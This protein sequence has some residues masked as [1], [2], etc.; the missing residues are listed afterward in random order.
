METLY[1]LGYF[2]E[3][4]FQPSFSNQL[5]PRLP[6]SFKELQTR[7]VFGSSSV[8][9]NLPHPMVHDLGDH[10]YVSIT[11]CLRHHLAHGITTLPLEH[12]EG[13]NVSNIS[14]S[15]RAQVVLNR[16]LSNNEKNEETILPVLLLK[17]SDDFEPNSSKQN[18]SSVWI[19]TVT[20]LTDTNVNR[21]GSMN[22]TYPIG[23]SRKK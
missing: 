5:I 10:S 4:K 11:E 21:M 19:S 13:T 15:K 8:Q 17:W 3:C 20:V 6:L 12:F 22:A 1:D 16:A 2:K 14:Q 9:E 23:I 18:R 7:F